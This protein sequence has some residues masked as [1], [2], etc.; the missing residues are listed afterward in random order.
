MIP[1]KMLLDIA[2]IEQGVIIDLYDI[3]LSEIVGNKTVLRFHNGLNELRRPITWQGNVYEPYP[4]KAQG[5][6]K[7]GQG[8]SNRPTLTSS[9][10]QDI[11]N[12]LIESKAASPIFRLFASDD[13]NPD[14]GFI[15]AGFAHVNDES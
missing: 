11:L 10:V 12:G 1:Q 14:E 8:T 15:K 4:I 6:E 2:K 7:N 5:F 13:V 9:N 3:D